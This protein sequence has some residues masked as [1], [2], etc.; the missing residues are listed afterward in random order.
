MRVVVSDYSGHAFPVQ[1]SRNLARRGHEVLHIY[2]ESFQTP[3]GRLAGDAA[4]PPSFRSLGVRTREPFAKLSFF[5]RRRQEIEIGK[6]IGTAICGFGPDIVLSG[7]VPLDA[8]RFIQR[9]AKRAGAGFIFW[10]QDLYGEAILRILGGR[11]GLLGKVVGQFYRRLEGRLIRVSDHAVLIAPEFGP[12]VADLAGIAPERMSVIENWAPLDEVGQYP[13]DNDWALANLPNA[14][15]RAVY[16]GTLG[17]KHNPALLAAVARAIEGEVIVFSEGD[18]ADGL[19]AQAAAEGLDNLHV[20][21]W[22]PFEDLPFALA[23]ADL[24]LVILEPDAGIFSV[25]SKVLTYMCAGRAI[26]GAVPATNLATRLICD[27]KAGLVVEPA[28]VHGFAECARRL[29]VDSKAREDLARE[30]RA[31]AERTFD[32]NLITSKFEA[33]LDRLY[34]EKRLEEGATGRFAPNGKDDRIG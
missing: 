21:G 31:F 13:R 33:V 20:R 32:I 3:K 34:R 1:L 12:L 28:D 11:L 26:L 29:A 4:D 8:Q 18:A 23:G 30:G 9:A 5:K 24:L 15:F 17:F 6:A 22:L 2:S 14:P 19:K 27:N 7:N 16:S 25:P 10:V